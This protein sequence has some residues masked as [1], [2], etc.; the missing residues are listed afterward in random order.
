M[1]T[2]EEVHDELQSSYLNL[3][4]HLDEMIFRQNAKNKL[5]DL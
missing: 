1:L 4:K 2:K 5:E 3:S